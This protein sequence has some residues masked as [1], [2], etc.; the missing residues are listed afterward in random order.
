MIVCMGIFIS[1]TSF[2]QVIPGTWATQAN[3]LNGK[4]GQRFTISFPPDG[5]ISG[6]LWGTDLYTADGSIAT[7]AVHAGLI[8][9]RRGGT[10]TIEIR[11]GAESYQ[12]S[13]RNGVTSGDWGSFG[14]SFVFVTGNEPQFNPNVT[15]SNWAAAAKDYSNKIG[16]RITLYF[17]PGG[18]LSG[19]LWGTDVYTTDG[20]IAT[21]AVHAGL[22]TTRDGGT[23]TIEIRPGANSYRGTTR[24][25]ATSYDWGPYERSFVFV[26]TTQN[27]YNPPPTNS[28]DAIKGSWGIQANEL[29][30]KP[31]QRFTISFPP[32][33]PG[34]R[35]WG[36]DLYTA[37][38]SIATAAVH[39]GLISPQRGGT[40]TIELRPGTD[41]YRGS[42]RNGVTSADWGSY[43][44]SFV[45]I[46]GNQNNYNPP[47][48]V[49]QGTWAT[50]ASEYRGRNGQRFTFYF[51]PGTLSSRLWGTELYTDDS[52]IATAAVHAGL[53]TARDGGTV[54]IEIRAGASSYR[55]STR[56]GVTSNNWGGFEG[57]FV[58]V[59]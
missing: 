34:S 30:G 10:V 45:F 19:R 13:T 21:A 40:V 12:G 28:P 23:V 33:A 31:G 24:H 6:R 39:S 49:I 25:G 4:P 43:G 47:P 22:I 20:S 51:P 14:M 57:S 35:L 16:D 5:T 50:Q 53:I 44:L 37:D 54:T 56:N 8:T 9:T 17:P 36:T 7:A 18:S 41:S 38:C 55:G 58:F 32:G 52:S 42:T 1:I 11:P 46:S 48:N 2:S 27:T 3:E 59:R 29:N 26:P 15:I